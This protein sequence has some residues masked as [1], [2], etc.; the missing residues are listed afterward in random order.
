MIGNLTDVN[1]NLSR[2]PFRRLPFDTTPE[3]VKKLKSLGAAQA[4]AGSFDGLLHKDTGSVNR[5]LAAQCKRF[6]EGMLIPFGSINPTLPDW[7]EELRRC[8]ED[9]EM[10]GIRLHPNYHQYKLDDERF[11][12]LLKLAS[13]RRLIVQIP[14]LMEDERTQHPL[15]NVP[16]V[17]IAPLAD[18]LKSTPKLKV[19]LL[20]AHR[21]VRGKPFLQLAATGQVW[22][23]IANLES[24]GGIAKILEQAPQDKILFGS[25]APFFIFE[26]ALLKLR[27]SELTEERLEAVAESNARRLLAGRG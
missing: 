20:N 24:V 27:E 5:R 15:V 19:V 22:F 10:P 8:A 13:E 1:V 16:H 18:V 12:D 7:E 26:S 14:V 11:A 25:H 2:W 6:G 21:S 23:D 4:W 3:L 9:H 17:D